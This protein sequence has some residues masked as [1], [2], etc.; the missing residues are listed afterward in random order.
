MR[1]QRSTIRITSA[2]KFYLPIVQLKIEKTKIKINEARNGP[3]LKIFNIFSLFG[4]VEKIIEAASPDSGY[5]SLILP[6]AAEVR[7]VLFLAE[8]ANT[9]FR[10]AGS[11]FFPSRLVPEER[12]P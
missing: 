11:N 9:N 12:K 3:A 7:L 1:H 2:V 8:C 6:H 10:F 5:F 4:A